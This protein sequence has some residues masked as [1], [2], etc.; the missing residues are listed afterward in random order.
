MDVSSRGPS[1]AMIESWMFRPVDLRQQSLLTKAHGPKHP[2][3]VDYQCHV[4]YQLNNIRYTCIHN[5]ILRHSN[6]PVWHNRW[7]SPS[8]SHS[9]PQWQ[10][11]RLTHIMLFTRLSC[12]IWRVGGNIWLEWIE[13]KNSTLGGV[14]PHQ[15]WLG[16]RSV[17]CAPGSTEQ[18]TFETMKEVFTFTLGRGNAK[19]TD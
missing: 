3:C 10:W 14:L 12:L 2:W 7:L 15:Q 18:A 4:N 6:V 17:Y 9:Y 19:N 8:K 16:H 5:S 1:S 11:N 13:S